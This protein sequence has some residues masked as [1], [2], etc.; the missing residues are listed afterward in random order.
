MITLYLWS[1]WR[2]LWP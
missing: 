2:W 1:D